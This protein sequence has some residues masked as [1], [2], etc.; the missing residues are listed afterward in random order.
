MGSL[1]SS[2]ICALKGL[3]YSLDK[4]VVLSDWDLKQGSCR[5][6]GQF[7]AHVP[8]GRERHIHYAEQLA[9]NFPNRRPY[10]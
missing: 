9:S 8:H 10:E 5:G 4:G 2:T 1:F 6:Y 3:L 7:V